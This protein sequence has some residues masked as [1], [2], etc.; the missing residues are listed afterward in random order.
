[1]TNIRARM[2]GDHGPHRL[3]KPEYPSF[4]PSGWQIL[5]VELLSHIFILSYSQRL[6][7]INPRTQRN[8]TPINVSQVCRSWRNAALQT[9]ELWTGIRILCIEGHFKAES[10]MPVLYEWSLRSGTADL[11]IEIES[12]PDGQQRVVPWFTIEDALRTYTGGDNRIYRLCARLQETHI[13][14][15]ADW[16]QGQNHTLKSVELDFSKQIGYS[17][18]DGVT[19][20]TILRNF[21]HCF[22][23][24][25]DLSLGADSRAS[26]GVQI[27]NF[28]M[29][30]TLRKLTLDVTIAARDIPVALACC[31]LLEELVLG[32]KFA[33]TGAR[34]EGPAIVLNYLHSLTFLFCRSWDMR[35]LLENWSL[36]QLKHLTIEDR[37]A[38]TDE[39]RVWLAS[40]PADYGNQLLDIMNGCHPQLRSLTLW[41]ES[42]Q[43][44]TNILRCLRLLPMLRKLRLNMDL[45]TVQALQCPPRSWQSS[46]PDLP[47]LCPLLEEMTIDTSNQVPS[48]PNVLEFW[49][50]VEKMIRSRWSPQVDTPN[51]GHGATTRQQADADNCF[52]YL[53]R[54]LVP[55]MKVKQHSLYIALKDCIAQGLCVE[56]YNLPIASSSL[57]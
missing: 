14:G 53:R 18:N 16:L 31:P 10:F 41:N 47:V 46:G 50:A 44:S 15:L 4:C 8:E 55:S 17:E 23:Q 25:V 54:V 51:N 19:F 40:Y 13:V 20:S 1:M 12:L 35:R 24:L 21:S 5:P 6:P 3:V 33:T 42:V 28:P 34:A 7:T 43:S 56:G 2:C 22:G 52:K 9:R 11:S 27:S 29:C 26:V 32:T 45:T 48:S 57:A 38:Q 49:P 30:G 37:R 39:G 36:P